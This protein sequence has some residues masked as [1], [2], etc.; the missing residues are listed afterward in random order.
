M[1]DGL[2]EAVKALR[3]RLDTHSEHI[4]ANEIRT[5]ATLIDPLLKALG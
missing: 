1:L 2:I 4:G 5:R 3:E